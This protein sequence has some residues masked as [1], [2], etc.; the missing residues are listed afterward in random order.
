MERKTAD[1][2]SSA[3]AAASL[4]EARFRVHA[5]RAQSDG[6]GRLALLFEAAAEASAV[7]ARRFMRLLRGRIGTTEENLDALLTHEMPGLSGKYRQYLADAEGTGMK[8]AMEVFDHAG[9]VITQVINRI[10]TMA[11][12]GPGGGDQP[13]SGMPGLR[14]HGPR[15]D[16][17]ALSG[18]QWGGVQVQSAFRLTA[19]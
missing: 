17:R 14:V 5:L 15:G 9:K 6:H 7:H 19:R 10:R 16:S 3:F 13:L 12:A 1:N 18:L 11:E 8:V 2:L 4:A